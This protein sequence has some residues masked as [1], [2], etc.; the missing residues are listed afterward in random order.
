MRRT[1]CAPPLDIAVADDPVIS[2]VPF[3]SPTTGEVVAHAARVNADKVIAAVRN[4]FMTEL[5]KYPPNRIA[6]DHRRFHLTSAVG[7]R[8]T[9]IGSGQTRALVQITGA[10]LVGSVGHPL[11]RDAL[12]NRVGMIN[13]GMSP[14]ET[15]PN[16]TY[17]EVLVR[18]R[19]DHD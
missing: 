15:D 6:V 8:R 5:P 19:R 2:Y 18:P 12:Y 4:I 13:I 1:F 9:A 7:L 14:G 16:R 11:H 3:P 10:G 17:C